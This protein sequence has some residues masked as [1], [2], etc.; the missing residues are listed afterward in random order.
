[1]S[2]YGAKVEMGAYLVIFCCLILWRILNSDRITSLVLF[3]FGV[4]LSGF[5]FSPVTLKLGR[6]KRDMRVFK[7]ER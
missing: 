5:W 7:F 3:Y 1:M 2:K 4:G 6:K